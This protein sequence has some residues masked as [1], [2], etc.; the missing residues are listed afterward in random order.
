MKSL[1]NLVL[2]V[3]C[4]ISV[5]ISANALAE[6]SGSQSGV[7]RIVGSI[8]DDPCTVSSQAQ[9]LSMECYRSGHKQTS[10]LSYQQVAAGKMVSNDTASLSMR[11]LNSQK[12]LG[13]VTVDYK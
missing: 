7:I 3:F 4:S 6:S 10:T 5:F 9:H 12:T 1:S 11:Y 8:V 2:S 13:I